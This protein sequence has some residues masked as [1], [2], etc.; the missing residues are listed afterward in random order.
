V[1]LFSSNRQFARLA[2]WFMLVFGSPY[3]VFCSFPPQSCNAIQSASEVL[4]ALRA[5]AADLVILLLDL[6]GDVDHDGRGYPRCRE[7]LYLG[8]S[9]LSARGGKRRRCC[10]SMGMDVQVK[11]WI[12]PLVWGASA[13]HVP[14]R[15]GL[16]H[17]VSDEDVVSIVGTKS[18]LNAETK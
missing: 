14:Q 18:G 12:F 1:A 10:L 2:S 8:I 17:V 3:S 11:K 5:A 9:D 16:A 6:V 7:L 15:C 4:G 13:K